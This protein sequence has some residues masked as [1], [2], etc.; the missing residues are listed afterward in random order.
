M[1]GTEWQAIRCLERFAAGLAF[2]VYD[3]VTDRK[4][5]L[6]GWDEVQ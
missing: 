4:A 6:T 3:V 1:A 5:E 2:P